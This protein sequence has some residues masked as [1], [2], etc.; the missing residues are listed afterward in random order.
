MLYV[1][2]FLGSPLFLSFQ[3]EAKRLIPRSLLRN[4]AH[5]ITTNIQSF[6]D[7]SIN[8]KTIEFAFE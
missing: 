1:Y 3:I 4:G 7:N 8:G 6:C 5:N 2:T